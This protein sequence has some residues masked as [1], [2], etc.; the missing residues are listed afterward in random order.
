M[1]AHKTY[2]KISIVFPAIVYITGLLIAISLLIGG[3]VIGLS[4]FLLFQL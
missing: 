1:D 4:S 2:E 3:I